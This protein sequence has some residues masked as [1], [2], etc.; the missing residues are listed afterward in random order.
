MKYIKAISFT[1]LLMT[2]IQSADAAPKADDGTSPAYNKCMNS[3]DAANG[4]TIA[5]VNCTEAELKIQDAKLN[6]TYKALMASL[7]PEQKPKVLAAQRLWI[8]FRDANCAAKSQSGGT[9]DQ[10]TLPDCTLQMTV[11]RT[12]ELADMK[13][14]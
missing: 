7:E 1:A 2:A 9:M 5:M 8:Q 4:V 14:Q 13:D 10:I 11:A 3:G 12:K 6:A